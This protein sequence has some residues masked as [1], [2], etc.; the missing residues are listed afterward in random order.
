MLGRTR[1]RRCWRLT[2]AG[3][4]GADR[5]GDGPALAV[6]FVPPVPGGPRRRRARR[7]DRSGRH[8][9]SGAPPALDDVLLAVYVDD[10]GRRTSPSASSTS[11]R[12]SGVALPPREDGRADDRRQV[13]HRWLVG[14]A[15]FHSD[16]V[17]AAVPRPVGGPQPV[18]TSV[19]RLGRPP[20]GGAGGDAEGGDDDDDRPGRVQG[21]E[22]RGEA[23]RR[24]D[25]AGEAR[26][27]AATSAA[28]CPCRRL[29]SPASPRPGRRRRG[30]RGAPAR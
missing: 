6:R 9:A 11:T 2:G 28:R 8:G 19:A 3:R 22:Q 26:R 24:D 21:V 5:W 20:P 4:C 15:Y 30:R 1:A 7:G 14:A 18:V 25:G 27:S 23:G 16:A 17:H 13:G 29:R 10:G 12:G